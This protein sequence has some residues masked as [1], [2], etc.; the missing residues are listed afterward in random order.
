MNRKFLV[1]LAWLVFGIA[2]CSDDESKPKTLIPGGDV[3]QT[4]TGNG[5]EQDT[6]ENPGETDTGKTEQDTGCTGTDCGGTVIS[7]GECDAI[8]FL[9]VLGVQD[10]VYTFSGDNAGVTGSMQTHCASAGADSAELVYGFEVAESAFVDVRLETP[11]NGE[12]DWVHEVREGSC[13]PDT[14]VY[15]TD[16][17]T[18]RFLARAGTRYFLIL[19]PNVANR[20]G[21]VDVE[22]AFTPAVCDQ[23]GLEQCVDGEMVICEGGLEETAYEC[24]TGC[25]QDRC[26]GD[27]CANAIVVPG[28]GSH[29]FGGHLRAFANGFEA[30]DR[31]SCNLGGALKTPGSDV[32][33]SLPG[34][35]AG[36]TVKIDASLD[37][38][39]NAIF[40]LPGCGAN[41]VCLEATEL[42]DTL[43]WV[44][45]ADGDYTVIIDSLSESSKP[46]EYV[47]EIY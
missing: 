29:S 34:L 1:V 45:P 27:L 37:D 19:E 17:E 16:P 13:T 2:G 9:G 14:R 31:A 36:Q 5:V 15:C 39:D 24:A 43:D 4:D 35:V 46:F 21:K 32:I 25:A 38:V 42:T 26:A 3:G 44:V 22:F 12:V 47:I 28:V 8:Q 40:V 18:S 20:V 10:G 23:P 11:P 6:G 7:D 41:D 33:F 30:F